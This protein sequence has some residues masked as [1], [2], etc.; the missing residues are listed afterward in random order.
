MR[1]APT[2][3]AAAFVATALTAPALAED[4]PQIASARFGKSIVGPEV[5]VSGLKGRAV[6]VEFW[7]VK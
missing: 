3:A 6:V 1:L 5:T 2:L 7:G 4:K